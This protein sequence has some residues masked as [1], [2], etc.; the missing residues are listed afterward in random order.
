MLSGYTHPH[1]AQSLA[2][3]G[4]PRNLKRCGGW[5][6]EREIPGVAYRDAMGCYPLFSCQNWSGLYKDLEEIGEELVSLS[7]VTDPFGEYDLTDLRHCFRDVV[8][9]FKEHFIMNLRRP[10]NE[11]VG[12]RH[13]KNA[14][15]ALRAIEVRVLEEPRQFLDHW[16]T[17]YDELVERHHISGIPAFSRAAFARQLEIPGTIV[18]YA[19]H[20]EKIIG[21][22]IYFIQGPIVHCHLGAVTR[23]GYELGAF[24]ALDF[25]SIEYF[26]E[27]V[28]W[29]NLGGGAGLN[30]NGTDGL[31]L[32]KKGWAT[33]SRTS[34]FCGRIFQQ[35]RYSELRSVSGVTEGNYFPIY[36]EGEFR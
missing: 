33:E 18:L 9:P 26:S 19:V 36:R 5:I 25:F 24:Y 20:Q 17:L 1:Y 2:E 30:Q 4:T 13:R 29:L 28:Q 16:A 22:Q 15:R 14:R 21:A 11:I 34:Y 6:L 12:R 10:L 23:T 3:F 32:Y 31:S 8:R 7:L 35:K 27:K